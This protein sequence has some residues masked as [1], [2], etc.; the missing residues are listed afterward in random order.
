MKQVVIVDVVV[1]VVVREVCVRLSEM[2]V[3]VDVVPLVD[4]V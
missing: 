4:D 2:S 3:A 1:P